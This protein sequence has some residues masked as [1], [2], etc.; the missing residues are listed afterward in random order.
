MWNHLITILARIFALL[1]LFGISI[2]FIGFELYSQIPEERK[3]A[4]VT[5]MEEIGNGGSNTR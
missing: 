5:F 1:F 3:Q 2:F 4:I